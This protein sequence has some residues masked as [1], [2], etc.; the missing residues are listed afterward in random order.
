M[1]GVEEEAVFDLLEV[2]EKHLNSQ[3]VMREVYNHYA[4]VV[5]FLP[6]T[7]SKALEL[8]YALAYPESDSKLE[9]PSKEEIKE[10]KTELK[11]EG[12]KFLGGKQ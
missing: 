9:K 12:R 7:V 8:L 5:S 2:F 1:Y 3:D 6:P 11:N 10:L 4:P